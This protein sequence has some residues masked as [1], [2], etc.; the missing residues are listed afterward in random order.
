MKMKY[1]KR[2]ISLILSIA[3]LTTSFEWNK[4]YAVERTNNSDEKFF[5]EVTPGSDATT[6]EEISEE[7]EVMETSNT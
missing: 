1:V 5:T 2:V 6:D 4:V 7:L 3:I